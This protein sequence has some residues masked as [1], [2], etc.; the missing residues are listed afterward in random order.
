MV[1]SKTQPATPSSAKGKPDTAPT[2]QKGTSSMSVGSRPI[3]KD[4][5]CI[6]QTDP[7][8][9]S[10]MQ[11]TARPPVLKKTNLFEANDFSDKSFKRLLVHD[12]PY[13]KILN[14][15]FKAGQQLPIHSHDIEG[16][17]C[18]TIV[19]GEGEFLGANQAVLPAKAGDVLVS[20][21]SEPH[22]LRAKTDLRLL[23]IIAPPI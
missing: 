22:G 8:A 21:I 23:V 14:F 15:N 20:A 5:E 17:V 19:E 10:E 1:Q 18:L 13:C 6:G 9:I 7:A 11:A 4:S 12:S 16:E 2:E 3:C